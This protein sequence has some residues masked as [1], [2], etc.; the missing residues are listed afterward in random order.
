[1]D[2][3]NPDKA[4]DAQCPIKKTA[5]IIEGKWTTLIIRELL[6]S[7][8]RFTQIQRALDGVSPKVLSSRLRMLEQNG[9]ITRTVF[10]TI[11]PTTEYALTELG[12]GLQPVLQAMAKFGEQ[13]PESV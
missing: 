7:K 5:S 6:S 8:K 12:A 11:P 1:M 10:P 9:L 2:S 13:L 3:F 4:C